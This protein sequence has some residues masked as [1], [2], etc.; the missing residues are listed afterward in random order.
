MRL[1]YAFT[2]NGG[3]TSDRYALL[4]WQPYSGNWNVSLASD[5]P[6]HPQ[7]IGMICGTEVSQPENKPPVVEDERRVLARELPRGVR[8]FFGR[9][10]RWEHWMRTGEIGKGPRL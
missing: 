4:L 7:G 6:F 8:K 5:R 10:L 9:I 2:D 1:T 3:K